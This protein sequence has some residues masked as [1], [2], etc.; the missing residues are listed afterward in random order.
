MD[1][2]KLFP[3]RFIKSVDLEGRDVT[4]EVKA[5]RSE[6]IDGKAKAVLS[7]QGT[8]KEMVMNRTNAEAIKLMFGRETDNWIGKKITVFPA[9]IADPFNGGTTTAIR[10]RG[11]PHISKAAT[12]TVQRGKKSI[13][14]SV[15]P[16]GKGARA[17]GKAQTQKA[18]EPPPPPHNEETGEVLG[19]PDAEFPGG[20]EDENP[21]GPQ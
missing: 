8:K 20:P 13:K 4:L 11:S 16:T 10:V 18:P 9:T 21:F 6:E 2:E 3:G 12:A 15:A 5:V 1:Y 19:E 17:N 7:F 14:V